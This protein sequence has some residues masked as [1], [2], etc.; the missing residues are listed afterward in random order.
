MIGIFP[1][2]ASILRLM[3]TVL[4]ERNEIILLTR[5]A[6]FKAAKLQELMKTDVPEKLIKLAHEQSQLLAA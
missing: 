1:N 4:I 3:G 6:V 2:E 5:H